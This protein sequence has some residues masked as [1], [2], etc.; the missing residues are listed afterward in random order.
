MKQLKSA[1]FWVPL[2]ESRILKICKRTHKRGLVI[3]TPTFWKLITTLENLFKG[4]IV[5][6]P[7]SIVLRHEVAEVKI[8]HEG[9]AIKFAIYERN[10][11]S[12]VNPESVLSAIKRLYKITH[13][14]AVF[15]F[16]FIKNIGFINNLTVARRG[17]RISNSPAM[18]IHILLNSKTHN[19]LY[20][21]RG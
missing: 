17:W 9:Y 4:D 14:V 15:K 10:N 7:K 20:K 16:C 2:D 5:R 19:Y 3:Y 6:N 18:C 13:Y 8:K 12:F 21:V 11:D 1:C